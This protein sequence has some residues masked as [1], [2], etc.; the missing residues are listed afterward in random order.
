MVD[1]IGDPVAGVDYLA[2][3]AQLR[4]WF[5]TDDDCRD[6]LE[7]LRW[8][9]GFTCPHCDATRAWRGKNVLLRCHD[10]DRRVSVTAGTFFQDTRTGV[11]PG[12]RTIT[13]A[14][15]SYPSALAGYTH[16]ACNESAPGAAPALVG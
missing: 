11:E 5:T 2:C 7:W 10:C 15:N 14:R 3:L 13:D 8:P 6:Y 16:K 12:T 9:D 4:A 1:R